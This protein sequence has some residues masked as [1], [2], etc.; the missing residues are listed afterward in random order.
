MGADDEEETMLAELSTRFGS[1]VLLE[2][3]YVEPDYLR[4][5]QK[6]PQ[7]SCTGSGFAISGRRILTNRHVVQ[8]ATDVRLRK[9]G[10]ARRWRART[11]AEGP[12]VDLAVLEVFSDEPEPD[13]TDDVESFWEGV[14]PVEW[15]ASG[16][17]ELQSSVNVVGYPTGGRTICVTEGVVSRVD[18]RNYRLKT[19]SA[20]PGHVIVIQIDAAINPGNSGGPCF[21]ERGRVVGVAFQGLEGSDAQNVGYII[22]TDTVLNF[23]HAIEGGRTYGGVQEVP[24]KW[25]SLQNRSLRKLLGMPKRSSGVVVTRVSPLAV[26]EH[27]GEDAF[28]RE[29][30]VITHIDGRTLGDDYTVALREGELMNADFLITGK[31]VGESTAFDVV[32]AGEKMRVE[33]VLGPLPSNA[34]REHKMDCVP[35]WLVIGGLLFVPLTCPLL[36]YPSS[37]E[38][39]GSG[40]LKIYDYIDAEVHKYRSELG[41]ESVI[42]IDILACD[43]NFGYYFRQSWRVL[44]TMN[45]VKVKNMAHLYNMYETARGAVSAKLGP[46][47]KK[48]KKEARTGGGEPKPAKDLTNAGEDFLIFRFRDKS[49]IVLET[50]DCMVSEG[51]VLEQ[52]GIPE[53]VS[54]NIV[55]QAKKEKQKEKEQEQEKDEKEK[56]KEG[57]KEGSEEEP[58]GEETEEGAQAKAEEG[59]SSPAE[60]ENEEGS[61]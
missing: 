44:D 58:K 21:D 37:E 56:E 18:C 13:G 40:Y 34:P 1:I 59:E 55:E 30:D 60:G 14:R 36:V 53:A 43:A 50:A 15:D 48:A 16:P 20:A 61:S 41:H 51:E 38:L 57:S 22:P 54:A 12:D 4:P 35:G 46:D 9:H 25:T 17:P 6:S 49:R 32:R 28:L 47:I 27:G 31:R 5:W 26:R 52:H 33:A 23:L 10:D 8:D 39:E 19:A 45:G 29:N 2:V 42:L 7:G 3:S 24:F 11:A